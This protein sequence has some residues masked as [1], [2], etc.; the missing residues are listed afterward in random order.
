MSGLPVLKASKS[1][2]KSCLPDHCDGLTY[3][4]SEY[5]ATEARI[6]RPTASGMKCKFS[7][8]I[9]CTLTAFKAGISFGTSHIYSAFQ[10]SALKSHP[11]Y[12]SSANFF[13]VCFVSLLLPSA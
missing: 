2:N 11:K 8:Y 7:I 12:L 9:P 10:T 3:I 4:H 5:G 1:T 13:C 6:G